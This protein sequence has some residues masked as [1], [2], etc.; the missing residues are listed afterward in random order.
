[1]KNLRFVLITLILVGTISALSCRREE[2]AFNKIEE[3]TFSGNLIIPDGSP[4]DLLSANIISISDMTEINNDGSFKIP[5]PENYYSYFYAED[6]SGNTIGMA[7]QDPDKGII[8]SDTSTAISLIFIFPVDWGRFGLN[9]PSQ[10]IG[11]IK[12]SPQFP[13]LVSYIKNLMIN[14]PSELMDYE[15]HPAILNTAAELILNIVNDHG[16]INKS[17]SRTTLNIIKNQNIGNNIKGWGPNISDIAGNPKIEISNPTGTPY[18]ICS[19]NLNKDPKNSDS[20]GLWKTPF[21]V[22]SWGLDWWILYKEGK[23]EYNLGD[24]SW[25]LMLSRID[26][27]FFTGIGNINTL[28]DVIT[29]SSDLQSGNYI[30]VIRANAHAKALFGTIL[31]VLARTL[32]IVSAVD[33]TEATGFIEIV[34][35]H[36]PEAADLIADLT[37]GGSEPIGRT[38]EEILKWTLKII[39][40][41]Q[42]K[43]LKWSKELGVK[44]AGKSLQKS[45]EN[46][47]V[48]LD[49]ISAT[50]DIVQLMSLLKDSFIADQDIV[51][52]ITQLNGN[53][54]IKESRPPTEPVITGTMRCDIDHTYSYQLLSTDPEQ[55]RIKYFI[56]YGDGTSDESPMVSSGTIFTFQHKWNKGT[57]EIFAYAVDEN[58]ASSVMTNPFYVI[59]APTDDFMETFEN[60][61]FGDLFDNDIW[62]VRYEEPSKILITNVAY[63]SN[64]AAKFVD[65]DPSIGDLEAKYAD[66]N[67]NLDN[68]IQSLETN[69]KFD[70]NLDVFGFRAWDVFGDFTSIAYYVVV[71][72]GML[73]WVKSAYE[74]SDETDFIPIKSV[75]AGQWYNLKLIINWNNATY[76]IYLDNILVKSGADFVAKARSNVISQAPDLQIVAFTDANCRS[77]YLDNLYIKGAQASNPE[78]ITI[79]SSFD[80][81]EVNSLKAVSK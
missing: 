43:I 41:N 37:L 63:N 16:G 58:G 27:W 56:H 34:L 9:H 59:A 35:E 80:K 79:K 65:Y 45:I 10:L 3:N 19:Y 33:P 18:G 1:M 73:K 75:S 81:S 21:Y 30:E 39:D 22:D 53:A 62:S 66:L 48:V 8:I 61:Q 24:G 44:I 78:F 20:Y 52:T 14:N 49:C 15:K 57:Y 25:I 28:R 74:L 64:R 38:K 26:P 69:F 13:V 23:A 77:F 5:A 68:N 6:A 12:K 76:D 7:Y 2:F 55:E 67:T 29:S 72:A 60:Y 47:T 36:G 46:I 50:E 71:D 54:I 42:D 70:N 17:D 40:L 11:E 51:Y 31:D 32:G 4:I